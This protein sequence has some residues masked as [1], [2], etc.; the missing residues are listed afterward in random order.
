MGLFA[1]LSAG[2]IGAETEIGIGFGEIF[3]QTGI[4]RGLAGDA[5]TGAFEKKCKGGHREKVGCSTRY[6][7]LVWIVRLR[8]DW[9]PVG[10]S[11]TTD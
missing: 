5:R 9:G 10:D 11:G 1:V 6:A 4:S 7:R 8:N 3:A 2:R